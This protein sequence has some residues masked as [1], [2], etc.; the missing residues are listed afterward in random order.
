MHADAHYLSSVAG[1]SQWRPP[2]AYS[3]TNPPH[4]LP[5]PHPTHGADSTLLGIVN[6]DSGACLINP[7]PGRRLKPGDA[8]MMMTS[9]NPANLLPLEEPL[10]AC[11]GGW[12]PSRYRLVGT[13]DGLLSECRRGCYRMARS[14]CWPGAVRPQPAGPGGVCFWQ[15]AFTSWVGQHS[16]RSMAVAR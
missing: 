7:L 15:C 14:A 6:R 5:T 8:L 1:P 16:S 9:S 2:A 3:P 4:M 11:L 12:D 10:H 13:A